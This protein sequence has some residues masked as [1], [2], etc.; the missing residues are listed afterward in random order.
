MRS[1]P[2]RVYQIIKKRRNT[3]GK[4]GIWET[5]HHSVKGGNARQVF[6]TKP[7]HTRR[8]YLF[9]F[10]VQQVL[11]QPSAYYKGGEIDY[12]ISHR[13]VSGK[14]DVRD[15]YVDFSIDNVNVTSQH[16]DEIKDVPSISKVVLGGGE[17]VF[18]YHFQDIFL[19]FPEKTNDI[20]SIM[21]HFYNFLIS[22]M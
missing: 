14:L 18:W 8:K 1:N 16:D 7:S 21:L 11:Q 19:N 20:C 4:V 17:M 6:S 15:T 3:G 10:L 9:C 22:K 2:F 5:I 13:V 12:E